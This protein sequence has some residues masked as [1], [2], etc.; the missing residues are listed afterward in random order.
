[1][2]ESGKNRV[3]PCNLCNET[4]T[5]R[6]GR[7]KHV[8]Q[9]HADK[10]YQ[11][12]YCGKTYTRNENLKKH[13]T[14]TKGPSPLRELESLSKTIYKND[15]IIGETEPTN[16]LID[17]TLKK[18]WKNI[19]GIYKPNRIATLRNPTTSTGVTSL[20]NTPHIMH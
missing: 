17:I 4:F 13:L 20:V 9:K 2:A 16:H 10:L 5:N 12:T 6:G 3:C 18:Q 11:C 1:M 19:L 8:H 15:N 7:S 14:L